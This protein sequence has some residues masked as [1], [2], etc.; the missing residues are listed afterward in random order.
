MLDIL[1]ENIFIMLSGRFFNRESAYKLCSSSLWLV[2]LFVCSIYHIMGSQE[3]RQKLAQS[4]NFTFRYMDDV[5]LLSNFVYRMY[6]I[7]LEKNGYHRHRYV[8]FHTLTV[9]R[10]LWTKPDDNRDY[11]NFHT[12]HLY[13]A[14][15]QQHL[16]MGY[17]SLSWYDI[18]ALVVPIRICLIE[19]WLLLTRK[20][21]NP[22]G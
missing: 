1:I 4:F 7:E 14:T 6:P 5:L 12:F 8:C 19:C 21:L 2:R 10:R 3:K 18:L 9:R 13:V 20:L 11:L 17:I 22:L 16:R 15:F